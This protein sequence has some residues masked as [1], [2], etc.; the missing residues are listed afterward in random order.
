MSARFARAVALFA[1]APFL[2]GAHCSEDCGPPKTSFVSRPMERTVYGAAFLIADRQAP[3]G[4]AL[5]GFDR[6]AL[7]V[8]ASRPVAVLVAHASSW[9]EVARLDASQLRAGDRSPVYVVVGVL[10]APGKLP[11]FEGASA[12]DEA[13]RAGWD[14]VVLLPRTAGN[15]PWE[16]AVSVDMGRTV[17][18]VWDKARDTCVDRGRALGAPPTFRLGSLSPRCG[19]G[20]RQDEEECDDGNRRSD[21]GCS[22]FCTKE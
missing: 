9:S 19:D 2:S 17:T 7:R 1:L 13:R 16:A 3:L 15:A 6:R 8:D 20:A 10:D 11:L 12:L 21:D 4:D 22:A 18:S 14:T 5:A